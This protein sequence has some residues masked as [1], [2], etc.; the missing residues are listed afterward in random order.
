MAVQY[1]DSR[2]GHPAGA[3]IRCVLGLLGVISECEVV[4]EVEGT[5]V[6]NIFSFDSEFI[7]KRS[8]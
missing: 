1:V 4:R 6:A 2:A 8:F 5:F 7:M 3:C